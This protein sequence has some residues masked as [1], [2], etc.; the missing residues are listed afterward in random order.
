LNS[1]AAATGNSRLNKYKQGNNSIIS[2]SGRNAMNGLGSMATGI[3]SRR[4]AHAQ[5]P[6]NE[7]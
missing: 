7:P 2:Q 6:T 5:G 3:E 1:A 4:N